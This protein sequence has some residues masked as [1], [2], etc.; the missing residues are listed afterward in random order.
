MSK[1]SL[2]TYS[3]NIRR[4]RQKGKQTP[5]NTVNEHGEILTDVLRDAFIYLH[6]KKFTCKTRRLLVKNNKG[7]ADL[8]EDKR[9]I[10]AMLRYGFFG[11]VSDIENDKDIVVFKKDGTHTEYV[12]MF[13]GLYIKSDTQ[14]P[15][16]VLST[17]GNAGIKTVFNAYLNSKV[18]SKFPEYVFE[19]RP[20]WPAGLREAYLKSDVNA[21]TI[22]AYKKFRDS[23]E[24]KFVDSEDTYEVITQIRKIKETKKGGF[25]RTSMSIDE[26]IR[27]NAKDFTGSDGVQNIELSVNFNGRQ[28]TLSVS[29]SGGHAPALPATFETLGDIKDGA[30]THKAFK[31]ESDNMIVEWNI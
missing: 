21:V 13:A 22:T 9:C 23:S 2:V 26:S 15:Y 11:D 27:K 16:I 25:Q 12:E 8:N 18:F 30:P 24:F 10:S 4:R 31:R 5:N 20:F 14:L 3:L 28:R 29:K 7:N 19:I 1:Y 17:Y 6:S